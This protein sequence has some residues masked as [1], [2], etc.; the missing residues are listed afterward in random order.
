MNIKTV[1]CHMD[2]EANL[3]IAVTVENEQSSRK[4]VLMVG[5]LQILSETEMKQKDSTAVPNMSIEGVP[6]QSS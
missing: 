5:N 4:L 6:G 3:G 2:N 1:M